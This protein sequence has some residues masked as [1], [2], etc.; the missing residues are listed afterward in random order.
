MK[1]PK[2]EKENDMT[3]EEKLARRKLSLLEV[4]QDLG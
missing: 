2:P 1:L 3:T 4:A